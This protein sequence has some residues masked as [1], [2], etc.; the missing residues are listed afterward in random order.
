[1]FGAGSTIVEE[2]LTKGTVNY[3]DVA[4]QGAF[5]GVTAGLSRA[6]TPFFAARLGAPAVAKIAADP[7]L[8]D[9]ARAVATS[10]AGRLKEF[11][12]GV[13]EV[14]A[15][16]VQRALATPTDVSIAAGLRTALNPVS[17]AADFIGKVGGERVG[18]A[19]VGEG[20]LTFEN[21]LK[22]KAV[23]KIFEEG[24]KRE[25]EPYEDFVNHP[26]VETFE[27]AARL[28]IIAPLPFPHGLPGL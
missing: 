5:G 7:E 24:V 15:N 9:A 12:G 28:P 19:V 1:M 20:A 6:L 18:A 27:K 10:Q 21:R 2:K 26:S 11:A 4:V 13:A 17:A 8:D 16:G 22:Q 23:E 14:A 3:R 25:A